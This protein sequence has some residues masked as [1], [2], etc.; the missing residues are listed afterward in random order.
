[1]VI[2]YVIS[3]HGAREFVVREV[4]SWRKIILHFI[5][6]WQISKE[7]ISGMCIFPQVISVLGCFCL[8]WKESQLNSL[9][10]RKKVGEALICNFLWLKISESMLASG[11]VGPRG[12]NDMINSSSFASLGSA[13]LWTSYN[14]SM[15]SLYCEYW[16]FQLCIILTESNPTKTNK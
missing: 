7:L 12:S 16:H 9:K 13:L 11:M 14:L 8:Q 3:I 15:T 1:M 10:Q 2:E 5:Y 6:I 4:T